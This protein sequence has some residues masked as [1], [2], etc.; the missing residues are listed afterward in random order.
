MHPWHRL[1]KRR[2][3]Q[4][5]FGMDAL[6]KE[7]KQLPT[8]SGLSE[9]LSAESRMTGANRCCSSALAVILHQL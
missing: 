2:M 9:E 3:R 1:P 8:L 6:E 7:V 4:W 5:A